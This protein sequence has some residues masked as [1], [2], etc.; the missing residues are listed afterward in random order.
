M[1][2][3]RMTETVAGFLPGLTI[4]GFS[5]AAGQARIPSMGA[6]LAPFRDLTASE[7]VAGAVRMFEDGVVAAKHLMATLPDWHAVAPLEAGA[8]SP[9]VLL[10]A[11]ALVG[12]I[13]V[14]SELASAV[15]NRLFGPDIPGRAVSPDPIRNAPVDPVVK[16]SAPEPK[17]A[18]LYDQRLV[19]LV[20][21]ENIA[22]YPGHDAEVSLSLRERARRDAKSLSEDVN[23]ERGILIRTRF[24]LTR[25]CAVKEAKI[26]SDLARSPLEEERL[27]AVER[28]E[29]LGQ[30][31]QKLAYFATVFA[32]YGVLSG[33]ALPGYP[34]L[35][36]GI[37]EI[38]RGYAELL[39]SLGWDELSQSWGEMSLLHSRIALAG[40][41]ADIALVLETSEAGDI[42][43]RP[44]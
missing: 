3:Q 38:E 15:T 4:G 2:V 10:G 33:G 43:T 6:V 17:P 44:E 19:K 32:E 1:I 25:E 8:A 29:T 31:V 41:S 16:K 39:E 35:T 40:T 7:P 28:M 30:F 23:G 34:T 27:N 18:G 11:A 13:F 26:I 21:P 9:D 20:D 37:A 5:P 14:M 22:P 42:V 12:G 24:K 36:A